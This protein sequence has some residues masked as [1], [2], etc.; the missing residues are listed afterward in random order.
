M[1]DSGNDTGNS[2]GNESSGQGG[3]SSRQPSVS[4]RFVATSGT[5]AD[6]MAAEAA[7]RDRAGGRYTM[8]VSSMKLV[9]PGAAILLLALAILWPS[10][11]RTGGN[12]AANVKDDLK[13]VRGQLRNFE[14]EAPIYVG[15]DDKNRPFKLRAKLARQASAK[16]DQVSLVQPRANV[17]LESGNY[18]AIS[19]SHGDY[20]KTSRILKLKGDVNV[21]HDANYTFKTQEATVDMKKNTAW[22]NKPVVATGP[23]ARI[24]ARGFRVIEGGQTVL[25]LGKSKVI[26]KVNNADLNQVF[27]PRLPGARGTAARDGR[28]GR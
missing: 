8:F 17:T 20:S 7:D 24:H 3:S 16:A 9:L 21:Y 18:V 28:S 14:M 1:N 12:I 25:F 10:L 6:G 5:Y 23:Q 22:G 2:T 27:G 15:V 11:S 26:L 13:S 4:R 19:A